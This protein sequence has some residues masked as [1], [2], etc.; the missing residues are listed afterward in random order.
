MNYCEIKDVQRE[1]KQFTISSTS[2]PDLEDVNRFITIV[3]EN[4]IEPVLRKVVDLPLTD[5]I[6][7]RYLRTVA[8]LGTI[9]KIYEALQAD[10]DR[11]QYYR[12][13]YQDKLNAAIKNPDLV[14]GNETSSVKQG[15]TSSYD[16]SRETRFPRDERQW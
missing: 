15:P 7:L 16:S 12:N 6:G 4:E 11:I 2:K 14:L 8:I 9:T 13:Q 1:L 10:I 5:D 3:S